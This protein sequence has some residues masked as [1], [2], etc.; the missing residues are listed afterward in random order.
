MKI[1]FVAQTT[2]MSV[3]LARRDT[4]HF[5]L[6]WRGRD[7]DEDGMNEEM[8]G[9]EERACRNTP[10]PLAVRTKCAAPLTEW[11]ESKGLGWLRSAEEPYF[12][13]WFADQNELLE[14]ARILIFCNIDGGEGTPIENIFQKYE[15][16]EVLGRINYVVI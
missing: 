10:G 7:E 13:V 1:C 15:N 14:L 4:Y 11:T 9:M 6:W 3:V 12:I 8:R 2:R 5:S 16:S